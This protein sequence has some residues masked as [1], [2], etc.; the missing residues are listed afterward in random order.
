MS[1]IITEHRHW[2][3]VYIC[4]AVLLVIQENLGC[5][6]KSVSKICSNRSVENTWLAWL[7]Y[8]CL[9][10]T[11]DISS[12]IF[13]NVF[14][15]CIALL[16]RRTWYVIKSPWPAYYPMLNKYKPCSLH[17]RF[18][19]ILMG[20]DQIMDIVHNIDKLRAPKMRIS[21]LNLIEIYIWLVECC[22]LC[23]ISLV[24]Y[25]AILMR[26][27]Y[28]Y[29]VWNHMPCKYIVCNLLAMTMPLTKLCSL[30]SSIR[31]SSPLIWRHRCRAPPQDCFFTEKKYTDP[32][33]L[34]S[35]FLANKV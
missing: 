15:V 12:H 7:V 35:A 21:C 9:C 3:P 13:Q 32:P 19:T 22:L 31:T 34:P 5:S 10:R 6:R 1:W 24:L 25:I 14:C 27:T 30:A 17:P 29:S 18:I 28:T 23:C 16:I 11:N 20:V 33:C 2:N 26:R 4:H 8:S